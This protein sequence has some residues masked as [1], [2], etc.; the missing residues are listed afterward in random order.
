MKLFTKVPMSSSQLVLTD[1]FFED[2]TV[3]VTGMISQIT[4]LRELHTNHTNHA[5]RPSANYSLPL[6]IKLP[7]IYVRLSDMLRPRSGA[8]EPLSATWAKEFIPICFRGIRPPSDDDDGVAGAVMAQPRRDS[9]IKITA[10]ARITVTNRSR[11]QLL[12]GNIDHDVS[13]DARVGQFVL[14]LRTD[15]GTPVVTL[16]ATRLRS[17][18]RLVNYIE[19]I[20]RA[21]KDV[22]P[23]SVT[24]REV[25]FTYCRGGSN[26][27]I[28]DPEAAVL[29]D[30]LRP[31]SRAW[32]VRLDLT[33]EQGVGVTLDRGNPHLRVLDFLQM[34]A[35]NYAFENIPS[36]LIFT[37][38]LFRGVEK[39]EEAW[40]GIAA[41]NE[42]LFQVFHK[43][44][45]WMTLRF[46]L[47]P[48][49]ILT[50]DIRPHNRK[51]KAMW[52]VRRPE[53]AGDNSAAIPGS[54][55][56]EFERVLQQRV[57]S[58]QGDGIK[59]LGT[60]AAAE[61]GAGIEKLMSLVDDAVRALV[62][63]PPGG[64][65]VGR[66][67][68]LSSAPGTG[69]PQQPPQPPQPGLQQQQARFSGQHQHR[70]HH[71][72]PNGQVH[73]RGGGGAVM[74]SSSNTPLVVLD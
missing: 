35:E 49:R 29:L 61:S 13:F 37:L 6:K 57:W 11:F 45:N 72:Q 71:Q 27:G 56:D 7:A 3:Y 74:G 44:L 23:V 15:M 12:K 20:Q 31:E 25:V 54:R 24:L 69:A 43:N 39:I 59:G 73:Q 2:L 65:P 22:V 19:A 60:S 63:T 46:S 62:G 32:R 9:R 51:G 64:V 38:P 30:A 67:Q 66:S 21:G 53:Q 17:L 8:A 55:N 34:A 41:R 68:E 28:N 33:R 5:S 70:Q 36:W 50:L 26:D 18:D 4:D 40:K 14:R 1:T 42:G 47:G 52:H 58:V 10:E 16:L 48:R